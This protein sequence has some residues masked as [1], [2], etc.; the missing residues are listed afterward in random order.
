MADCK[1]FE[2][3]SSSRRIKMLTNGTL[4]SPILKLSRNILSMDRYSNI[5]SLHLR[6]LDAIAVT[7][8]RLQS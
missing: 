4:S 7:S 3:I 6:S 2:T 8:I 1:G 5:D